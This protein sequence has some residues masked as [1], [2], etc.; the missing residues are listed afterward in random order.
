MRF[1]RRHKRFSPSLSGRPRVTAAG[2]APALVGLAEVLAMATWFSATAVVPSLQRAW[3]LDAGDA[4]WLT[5][6]VQLPSA[7]DEHADPAA[8]Q[9][10]RPRSRGRSHQ[11][12]TRSAN[13]YK[14]DPRIYCH[15]VGGAIL[16]TVGVL[17]WT[18]E[19]LVLNIKAQQLLERLGID[20]FSSV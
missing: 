8:R 11:A 20:F 16:I 5:S 19:L 2:R 1:P 13:A 3:D 6:A 7:H 18:G 15:G 12:P 9:L 4:S 17:I 14:P 10:A